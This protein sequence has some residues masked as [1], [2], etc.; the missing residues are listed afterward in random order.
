MLTIWGRSN[1]VNVR[2]VLWTLD[3]LGLEHR[4]ILAGGAFG[5]VNEDAFLQRNPN[6]HVPCLQH[7]DFVLWESNAIVRY[8]ADAFGQGSLQPDDAR[9][10]A[11]A[12][13]WM[14]WSSLAMA[15]P[16]RDI[17]WNSVRATPAQRNEEEIQRGIRNASALLRIADATLA[18]QD[19]LSGPR[20]GIGDIPLG[21]VVQ[22]LFT[23]PYDYADLPH[24]KAWYQR[25]QKR[26]AFQ[27]LAALP[28][29]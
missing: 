29:A 21:C 24:L 15:T 1:S 14:D 16:F 28:L 20:L 17:F 25:L 23:L 26:P 19:Y 18:T 9:S 22:A 6:G 10:R 12:D 13:K 4:H 2:K 27:R 8:L 5:L 3:E 7:D 11:A